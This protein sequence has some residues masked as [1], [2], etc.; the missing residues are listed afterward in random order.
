MKAKFSA[1]NRDR[2]TALWVTVDGRHQNIWDIEKKACTKSVQK[3][4][5]S[6]FQLGFEMATQSLKFPELAIEQEW[7]DLRDG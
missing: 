3:A 5:Q 1:T 7:E 2:K 6:A 4:I